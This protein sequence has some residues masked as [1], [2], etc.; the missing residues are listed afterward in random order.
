MTEYPIFKIEDLPTYTEIK[1]FNLDDWKDDPKNR[2]GET[3]TKLR[4][5]PIIKCYRISDGQV[6]FYCDFCQ[7]FHYHGY[8]NG[9]PNGARS[10]HCDNLKSFLAEYD[11]EIECQH[12]IKQDTP[13][14]SSCGYEYNLSRDVNVDNGNMTI[15]PMVYFYGDLDLLPLSQ[16]IELWLYHIQTLRE[17]KEDGK[18]SAEKNDCLQKYELGITKADGE[19]NP[20]FFIDILSGKTLSDFLPSNE[21]FWI[22]AENWEEVK[23]NFLKII[24]P[25]VINE[26]GNREYIK[27]LWAKISKLEKES[28]KCTI[29]RD[30]QIKEKIKDIKW[31]IEQSK[32]KLE[33]KIKKKFFLAHSKDEIKGKPQLISEF[34]KSYTLVEARLKKEERKM[35]KNEEVETSQPVFYSFMD[36]KLDRRFDLFFD[37][38]CMDFWSYKIPTSDGYEVFAL[39]KEKLPSCNCTLTGMLV[40]VADLQDFTKNLKIKSVS[41]IFFVK[42]SEPDVKI[43]PKDE[44]VNLIK[45]K[46]MD[47]IDWFAELA[48]H[49]TGSLNLMPDNDFYLRSAQLLSGK[50]DGY[51]LHLVIM[52]SPG[53][54]KSWGFL[55]TTDR[56]INENSD[57]FGGANSRAKGLVVSFRETLPDIGYLNKC[58]RMGF[59]DEVSKLAETELKRHDSIVNNLFGEWNDPLDNAE[60]KIASGNGRVEVKATAKFLMAS[61]PVQ[62]CHT[63]E[64]HCKYFDPTMMSRILWKV[65]T[66]EEVEFYRSEHSVLR[67]LSEGMVY[68]FSPI[69]CKHTQLQINNKIKKKETYISLCL[70]GKIINSFLNKNEFLTVFDSTNSF[71]CQIDLKKVNELVKKTLEIATGKMKTHVW[72]AR[73]SHHV[74]LLI[75][76]LVKTRCLF[77][78][79]DPTFTPKDEDYELAEKILIPII[80]SWEFDMK[81]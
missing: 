26:T 27:E 23:E 73:A 32:Q 74:Y 24:A 40:P 13:G 80:K 49:P 3:V 45:S 64:D 65:Q 22:D 47:L 81:K 75:D 79:Y 41:K 4:I 8:A 15:D 38:I 56:L 2:Q 33:K 37:Q 66:Q 39:S 35:K 68:D 17:I 31:L 7:K 70:G 57:I 42:N 50:R 28:Y 67:D 43:L 44:L 9:Y 61:N 21:I 59:V 6:A 62:F 51:P 69:S 14:L 18:Q 52:G 58:E 1:G 34:K 30:V 16:K 19:I 72:A 46:N 55:G 12:E 5:I 78:D 11:Y 10:P 60:R 53:T 36:E 54:K 77:Q 63:L 25:I 29:A 76:G 48:L 20:N 71:T